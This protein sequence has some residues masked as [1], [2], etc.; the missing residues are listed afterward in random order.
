MTAMLQSHQSR[1]SNFRSWS[2]IS[3]VFFFSDGAGRANGD[4]GVSLMAH[5]GGDCQGVTRQANY[6]SEGSP[7]PELKIPRY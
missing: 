4:A 6:K 7:R 2:S 5:P 1:R 3:V